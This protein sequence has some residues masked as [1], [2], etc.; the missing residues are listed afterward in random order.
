MD[1]PVA[2]TFSITQV[3]SFKLQSARQRK[4]LSLCR[5]NRKLVEEKNLIRRGGSPKEKVGRK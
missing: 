1:I 2:Q 4:S 3:S 5:R